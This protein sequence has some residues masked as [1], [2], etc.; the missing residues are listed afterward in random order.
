MSLLCLA[1]PFLAA[2]PMLQ[3]FE[4]SD[5]DALRFHRVYLTNGN[6][7]DGQLLKDTPASVLL[8]LRVGEMT[9]RRDMIDRVEFVKMRD[10]FQTPVVAAVKPKAE[11]SP[12]P[13]VKSD[14]PKITID[15]KTP[16]EIQRKVDQMVQKLRLS[17]AQEKVFPREELEALGD[18]AVTYLASRVPDMDVGMMDVVMQALI[19]MKT[20]VPN[21]ILGALLNHDK[22]AVRSFACSV[23]GVQSDEM[24][25]AYVRPMLKDRDER[26]RLT[27]VSLLG[28]VTDSEW[29]DPVG[30]LCGDPSRD[31]RNSAIHTLR[32]V[33]QKNDL[34]DKCLQILVRNLNS[35][36]DAVREDMVA[37]IAALGIK[38][39]WTFLTRMLNDREAKVRTAAASGLTALAVDESGVEILDAVGRERDGHTRLALIQLVGRLRLMKAMEPML[40]WLSDSDES[41][42]KATVALFRVLT[43]ET[44]GQDR[45]AWANWLK[46]KK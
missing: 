30:D 3:Q 45:E 18:Q 41:V 26:V 11:A 23:L 20:T 10:R 28:S 44:L 40:D 32:R 7:I 12:R 17:A 43:G 21:E 37:A 38:D 15:T 1:V 19:A 42:R 25:K 35:S 24:K 39:S 33:A 22:P 8:K 34:Q 6:F 46:N 14:A 16:P 29:L 31:V 2:S 36:S 9:I 13:E 4:N 27:A 5:S